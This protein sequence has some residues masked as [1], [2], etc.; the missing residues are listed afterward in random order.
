MKLEIILLSLAFL[1]VHC[2][3]IHNRANGIAVQ[4]GVN[5][6]E[7]K[8]N[9]YVKLLN[10]DER[11]ISGSELN[12][13]EG[14]I[15]MDL[16]ASSPIYFTSK[17]CVIVP[18]VPGTIHVRNPKSE[19]TISFPVQDLSQ[20]PDFLIKHMLP[21]RGLWFRVTCDWPDPYTERMIKI[22]IEI[23]HLQDPGGLALSIQLHP[24]DTRDA[25][26]RVLYTKKI[27][28]LELDLPEAYSLE[29]IPA[30]NYM[31]TVMGRHIG[32]NL[33]GADRKLSPDYCVM[34]LK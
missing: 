1:M 27:G 6:A 19:S 28:Q 12:A 8:A 5:A 23:E 11:E 15:V 16:L 33:H 17:G 22:P 18:N 13:L 4:C 20:Q 24:L 34:N 3:S 14:M 26:M 2:Q 30:G 29:T 32:E 7:V 21:Y 10:S 9:K 25:G 31:I